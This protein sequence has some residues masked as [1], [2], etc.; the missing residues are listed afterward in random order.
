MTYSRNARRR[1][2]AAGQRRPDV[3][4]RLRYRLEKA[5]TRHRFWTV[6]E[7]ARARQRAKAALAT[8]RKP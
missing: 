1:A 7:P 3:Q 2:I 6:I 8:T 5:V 4:A